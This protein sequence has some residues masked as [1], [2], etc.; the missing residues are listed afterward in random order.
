MNRQNI[1]LVAAAAGVTALVM[2]G[3]PALGQLVE[4]TAPAPVQLAQLTPTPAPT[5][6]IQRE[7]PVSRGGVMQSFAPVVQS[8][9]PAVVNV[10]TVEADG[11]VPLSGR[12]LRPVLLRRQRQPDRAAGNLARLRRHRRLRTA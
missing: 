9:A 12:L 8:A 2:L 3:V 7:A 4:S 5:P 6:D 10:Y 11:G 1:F